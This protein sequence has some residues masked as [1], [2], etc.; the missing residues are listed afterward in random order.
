MKRKAKISTRR[1]EYR[2]RRCQQIHT[3]LR[4]PIGKVEK[5][6]LGF[7]RMDIPSIGFPGGGLH[8]CADGGKGVMDLIGL[9]PVEE[10]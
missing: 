6:V 5:T 1:I 9:S 3:V 10:V 8:D 2:C 7:H 4:E